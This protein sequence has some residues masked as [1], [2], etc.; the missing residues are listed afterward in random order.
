MSLVSFLRA[1]LTGQEARHHR[2]QPNGHPRILAR[3]ED[4]RGWW[5]KV[6]PPNGRR[7]V[8]NLENEIREPAPVRARKR[9]HVGLWPT[10]FGNW[11]G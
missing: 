9:Q 5:V 11:C 6:F 2:Y 3:V 4:G 7:R 10:A 8:V 1:P